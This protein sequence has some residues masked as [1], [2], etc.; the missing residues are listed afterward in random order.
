MRTDRQ[1]L[2]WALVVF[3]G[4]SLAFNVVNDLTEGE[5]AIV[6]VGAQLATLAIILGAVV[7]VMRRK[8]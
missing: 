7:L 5:D 3:F 8:G 4:A 2:L 6:R 1:T